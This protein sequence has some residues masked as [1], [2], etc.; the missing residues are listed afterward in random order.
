MRRNRG[1]TLIELLVVMA[2]IALLVGLLLP[3]L[4]RARQQARL[5]KDG[6]QI[7]QIHKAWVAYSV[8]DEGRLPIPGL[9]NRLPL[10]GGINEPGRGDE[11]EFQNTTANLH[12]VMIM[13]NYYTPKLLIGPTEPSGI[14]AEDD[15]YNWEVYSIPEDIYWDE[16]FEADMTSECNVSYASMPIFGARK[17]RFWR[18]GLSSNT[19]L[20]SNRGLPDSNYDEQFSTVF[21]IHG[22]RNSW[23]G[24]VLYSDNSIAIENNY[25]PEKVTYQDEDGEVFPDHLFINDT[26]DDPISS[27]RGDDAFL[28]I[29]TEVES[30]SDG[31]VTLCHTYDDYEECNPPID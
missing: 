24:N 12:S 10:A 14:V 3:A 19:P 7:Q 1:F 21:Q 8:E 23:V 28:A 5:V 16:D 22:D 2:I 26:G 18:D 31:A 9:I 27:G 11:D 15:N 30:I 4:N 25:R 29:T 6:T 17:T 13:Q 20:L